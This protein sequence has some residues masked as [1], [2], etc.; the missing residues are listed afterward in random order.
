MRVIHYLVDRGKGGKLELDQPVLRWAVELG[1][2][3]AALYRTLAEMEREGIL[4]RQGQ[5]LAL[6]QRQSNSPM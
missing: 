1:A 2:S 6:T 5:T 4:Q 3:H